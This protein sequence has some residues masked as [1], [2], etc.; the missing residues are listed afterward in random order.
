VGIVLEESKQYA[1][2]SPHGATSTI[3][4]ASNAVR[5]KTQQQIIEGVGT[6]G[7]ALGLAVDSNVPNAAGTT[8]AASHIVAALESV[9]AGA[10][11]A[12]LVWVA[13]TGGA[14]IARQR[15]MISGGAAIM[16]DG[17]IAGYPVVVVGGCS[18]AHLIFGRWRDLLV[19][20][21]QPLEISVNPFQVFR[22][23]IVGL[24]AWIR[25]DAAPRVNSSFYVIKSIT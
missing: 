19:I 4:L 18:G 2:Q 21:R 11:D 12:P 23:D 24:R 3:E 7:E 15:E 16:A 8:L 6:G 1:L 5:V 22:A 9:E 13:T 14:K 10:G 17:K 20:E 25:F